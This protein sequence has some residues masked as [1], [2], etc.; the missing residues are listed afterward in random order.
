MSLKIYNGEHQFTPRADCV[1]LAYRGSIAHGT[2]IP[3]SDPNHVDDID[4]MGFCV[5][6]PEHYLGLKEWGSRGTVEERPLP[7]DVVYYDIKKAV[8]LLLAGNPN[9]MSMLWTPAAYRLIADDD[10]MELVKQRHLFV[11]KHVYPAFAGY[12]YAQ[13]QKM[14]SRDPSDLREYLAITAELKHRGKHPN[15]KGVEMPFTGERTSEMADVAHWDTEKLLQ[16]LKGYQKKGENLGYLGDKR[17]QLVLEYGY[18]TKNAAHL[19]RLLRMCI[20]FMKTGNMT[21]DRRVAGDA[22]ELRAIKS[23]KWKLS[24]VK[25]LSDTLFEDAKQAKDTSRLPEGPDTANVERLL[26]DILKG[27]L[28]LK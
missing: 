17:K 18:D 27:R 23:G 20:E 25:K 8:N 19:V 7:W 5:G 24:E 26:V 22:Q 28:L 15:E 11:G 16:R 10:V 2:Y 1:F 4:L 21:V 12:A 9:I 14:T 3:S 6:N 13:L